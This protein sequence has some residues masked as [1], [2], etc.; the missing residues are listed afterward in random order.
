MVFLFGGRFRQGSNCGDTFGTEYL[1]LEDFIF[2]LPN[3]RL[4]ILGF[5]KLEDTSLS[6]TGNAG[7]KDQ[8]LALKWVQKNIE[9]FGGDPNNVTIC[10]HSSGASMVHYHLFSPLSR[11][12]FH[13]A[14][15]LS[16]TVFWTWSEKN[17]FSLDLLLDLLDVKTRSESEILKE[18][19]NISAQTIMEAQ[20]TYINVSI[21]VA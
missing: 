10:G 8:V 7:L 14:I 18:L 6:V 11:G 2:V 21:K 4:G 9:T 15:M 5:L 17:E 12:L 1:L 19:Q 16:G 20:D 3:Y 13:K